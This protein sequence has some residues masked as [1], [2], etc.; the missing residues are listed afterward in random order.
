MPS[1]PVSNEV[2]GVG[3]RFMN[4]HPEPPLLENLSGTLP[5]S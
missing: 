5:R 3:L 1:S 4:H 2:Y